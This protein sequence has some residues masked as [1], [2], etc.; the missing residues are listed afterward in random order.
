[1]GLQKFRLAAAGAVSLRMFI[2][3]IIARGSKPVSV[4]NCNPRWSAW[5]SSSRLNFNC[6]HLVRQIGQRPRR[7]A[8]ALT[9]GGDSGAQHD[10]LSEPAFLDLLRDVPLD[11]V[12]DLM[13]QHAGQ[14]RF[15]AQLFIQSHRDE[16]LPAGQGESVDRLRVVEQMKLIA[17]RAVLRIGAGRQQFADVLDLL[18]RGSDGGTSPPICAD[19][20]GAD[21]R[22]SDISSSARHRNVL[23][24]AGGGIHRFVSVIG[25]DSEEDDGDRR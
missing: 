1:M 12:P 9:A 3:S 17:I 10:R 2:T 22:P 15:V 21:C 13:A 11:H 7:Q 23:L 25:N 20:C 24:F 14:F 8:I 16:D 19:I 4:M 5:D 6:D 18:A